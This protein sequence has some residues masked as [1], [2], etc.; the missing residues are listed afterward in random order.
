MHL[1]FLCFV[2][3]V[4]LFIFLMVWRDV[5]MKWGISEKP[6]K[7]LLSLKRNQNNKLVPMAVPLWAFEEVL[8]KTV[9]DLREGGMSIYLCNKNGCY[10]I[11]KGD[12]EPAI[13][14]GLS[15]LCFIKG[16]V[17]GILMVSFTDKLMFNRFIIE[18]NYFVSRKKTEANKKF[19]GTF[20][21][22]LKKNLT[23]DQDPMVDEVEVVDCTDRDN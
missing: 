12:S 22:C 2:A 1:L 9:E 16:D 21:E 8:K 6:Q 18:G 10:T 23:Q 7:C 5:F 20:V 15:S 4:I 14:F 19:F 17:E 11:N 13:W 3:A